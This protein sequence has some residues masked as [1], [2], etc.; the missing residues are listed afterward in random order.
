MTGSS[1]EYRPF[2]G[3]TVRPWAVVTG[4]SSGIGEALA[5]GLAARGH[6]VWLV[7]RRGDVLGRL[8]KELRAEHGVQVGISECDLAD[9]EQR[10]R[11]RAELAAAQVMILC[12]NAGFP[13]C[14]E[15]TAN[16]PVREAAEIEVNVAAVHDL[17]LAVLPGMIARGRGFI[18]FTGSTAGVQPVPTAATYAASKAFVNSFAEA[19]HAELVGTGVGC[20]LLA[21]GPVR[22]E[23][24][25]VGGIGD[26]EA[27]RWFGWKAPQQVAGQALDAL[28]NGRRVIVPGTAA[29]SQAFLGRY[30]PRS[31]AFRVMRAAILPTLRSARRTSV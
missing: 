5:R 22:S 14:G 12:N 20:T 30:L 23:F 19:L 1:D 25:D 16:D 21:P 15:L 6:P 31:V 9:R 29:K 3:A 8:G 27:T 11:L 13:T 26:I 10:A 24:S 28:E 18:L 4:A 7:A 2:E 17:T